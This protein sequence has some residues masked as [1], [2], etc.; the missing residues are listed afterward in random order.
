METRSDACLSGFDIRRRLG[1]RP[2]WCRCCPAEQFRSGV[3]RW[4]RPRHTPTRR[5][6]PPDPRRR[7]PTSQSSRRGTRRPAPGQ[8][9]GRAR[10][11][12]RMRR[13]FA[14]SFF[15]SCAIR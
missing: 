9:C 15:S 13:R 14:P 8:R 6:E 7:A 4:P 10:R 2:A 1:K 5:R 3:A 11:A 12:P